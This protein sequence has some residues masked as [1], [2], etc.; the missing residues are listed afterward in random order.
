MGS[1]PVES[2]SVTFKNGVAISQK[3]SST[4]GGRRIVGALLK[5][6]GNSYWMAGNSDA[7]NESGFTALPGGK[8][9]NKYG[10]NGLGTEAYFW[11]ASNCSSSP[12]MGF[13]FGGGVDIQNE[14]DTI[15]ASYIILVDN[16]SALGGNCGHKAN[17][18][19]VRC[20]MD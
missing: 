7:T 16:N 14:K 8:V 3:S 1:H 19:S 11:T 18:Y 17:G 12:I 13:K 9:D 4:P 5:A 2:V 10:F 20:V 6:T 15:E